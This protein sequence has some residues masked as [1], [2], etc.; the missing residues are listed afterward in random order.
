M[1]EGKA[2]SATALHPTLLIGEERHN[3]KWE[4][5]EGLSQAPSHDTSWILIFNTTQCHLLAV[6]VA[7][8]VF[9]SLY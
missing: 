5:V 9:H 2:N 1:G 7:S 8:E 6:T 4:G 3:L